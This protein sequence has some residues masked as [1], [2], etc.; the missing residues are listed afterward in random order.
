MLWFSSFEAATCGNR[1]G[2][3]HLNTQP[4]L[5][6]FV[7]MDRYWKYFIVNCLSLTEGRLYIW[8]HWHQDDNAN[9]HAEWQQSV[10][11]IQKACEIYYD[12]CGTIDLSKRY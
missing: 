4:G 5:L 2:L 12:T 1:K 8:M 9:A 11:P 10:V 7:W 6:A 3:I